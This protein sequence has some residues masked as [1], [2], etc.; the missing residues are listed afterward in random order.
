MKKL[1]IIALAVLFTGT[2]SSCKKANVH[3]DLAD[4]HS[5]INGFKRDL[6]SAD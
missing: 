4:V 5:F 1:I 6:G 2:V 3:N